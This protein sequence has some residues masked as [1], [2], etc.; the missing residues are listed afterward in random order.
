[1][2]VCVCMYTWGPWLELLVSG[3]P[4]F[5]KLLEPL[6]LAMQKKKMFEHQ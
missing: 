4:C 5:D 1:M 6:A 2:C 3:Q